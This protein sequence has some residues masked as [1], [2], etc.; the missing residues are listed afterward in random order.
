MI[1]KWLPESNDMLPLTWWKQHPVFLSAILAIGGALS[2][3]IFAIFGFEVMNHLVFSVASAF[4]DWHLWT[5]F[6]YVIV[7]PPSIWI[8]IG[9]FLLWRFGEAVERHFGRRIFVKLLLL[10]LI[11]SPVV[12]TLLYFVGFEGVSCMGMMELEFGV[13]IAFATLYPRAKINIFIAS[14]DAWVLA[15]IIVSISALSTIAARDWASLI[16]LTANVGSAYLFIR[17]QKGELQLPSFLTI[18]ILPDNVPKIAEGNIDEIL[19]KINRG[20]LQSLSEEE[21]EFLERAGRKKG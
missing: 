12:T 10:L 2:M 14:I 17:Y 11:V 20:G 6:T 4:G 1:E 9:C 15:A 19:D 3:V 18:K 7:N 16:L 8:A 5:P 21:R 13:F